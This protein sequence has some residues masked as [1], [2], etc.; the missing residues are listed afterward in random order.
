MADFLNPSQVLKQ[1]KLRKDMIACDFGSGS[2]GWAIPLAKKLENGLVYAIDILEEPLSVLRSRANLERIS[3]I[4]TM[5][6]NVED[7]KGLKIA[8][9]SVD[10]VLMTN[11][12]FQVEDKKT[13]FSEAKRI[14]KGKGKILVVDWKTDISLGPREGRISEKEIKKIARGSGLRLEKEFTAGTCHY[15]LIFT[16]LETKLLTGLGKS[17]GAF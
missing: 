14:L 17:P 10:L 15:G 8:P 11:L 3:N 16:P 12:L 2:G 6:A 9:S 4:K 5:R 7:K 13:V 1:L